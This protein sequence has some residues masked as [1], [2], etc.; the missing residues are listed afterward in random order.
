MNLGG[1]L[2]GLEAYR[3]KLDAVIDATRDLLSL[4]P[5]GNSA[6]PTPVPVA[7][8]APRRKALPAPAKA[9]TIGASATTRDTSRRE[10]GMALLRA[11]KS[12]GETAT[13]CG[14]GYQTA[15]GWKQ[16]LLNEGE[17]ER[18]MFM[19]QECRQK[20]YDPKRCDHCQEKR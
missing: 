18:P 17:T 11:G 7:V 15:Y 3:G 6:A 9:K 16:R 10:K 4:S 2:A 13:A 1:F 14:V 8:A 19:C 20:G 12:V 5:S